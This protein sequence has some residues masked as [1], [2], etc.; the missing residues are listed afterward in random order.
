MVAIFCNYVLY[1]DNP[2]RQYRQIAAKNQDGVAGLYTWEGEMMRTDPLEFANPDADFT[3]CK[4][5]EDAMSK[6]AKYREKSLAEG[7]H[8]YTP[9]QP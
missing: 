3:L 4:S 1:N 7:W 2:R 5:S 8:D 9:T 6:A